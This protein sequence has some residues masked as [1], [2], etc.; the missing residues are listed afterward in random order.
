[1][2][3]ALGTL[4]VAGLFGRSQ[5]GE[6]VHLAQGA[7]VAELEAPALGGGE[8]YALTPVAVTEARLG[9]AAAFQRAHQTESATM[10]SRPPTAETAPS[11]SLPEAAPALSATATAIAAS[12]PAR[13]KPAARSA[14]APIAEAPSH[15]PDETPPIHPTHPT[16]PTPATPAKTM[17]PSAPA[18]MPAHV[19]ESGTKADSW[20]SAVVAEAPS[21]DEA[22]EDTN[23]PSY[24]ALEG[25]EETTT[26]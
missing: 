15:A 11:A 8:E 17:K 26:R 10:P 22:V 4:T 14:A 7:T 16:H 18:A 6:F 23:E 3:V 1:M 25:G 13:A 21:A 5:L 2:V 24:E 12:S 20:Q 19:E 9:L